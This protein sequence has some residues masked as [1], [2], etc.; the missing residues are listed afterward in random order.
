MVNKPRQSES[1]SYKLINLQPAIVAIVNPDFTSRSTLANE[2]LLR[3]QIQKQTYGIN[4]VEPKIAKQ[5][6]QAKPA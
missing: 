5:V 6:E 2:L 4:F 3:L 1:Q